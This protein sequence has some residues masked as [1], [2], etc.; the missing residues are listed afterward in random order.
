MALSN[1]R[2]NRKAYIKKTKKEMLTIR[3]RKGGK[4]RGVREGM[5]TNGTRGWEK[6]ELGE[7]IFNILSP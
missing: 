1:S 5:W 7:K 3:G 2:Q 4:K 6:R